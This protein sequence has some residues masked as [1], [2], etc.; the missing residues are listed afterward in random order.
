MTLK[1]P[2]IVLGSGDYRPWFAW[3]PVCTESGHTVWLEQVLRS[4]LHDF[5]G[6]YFWS[7]RRKQ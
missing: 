4:R 7:Y 5:D 2:R 1:K 6:W 3:F